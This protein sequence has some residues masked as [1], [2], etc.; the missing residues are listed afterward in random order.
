[1]QNL[2]SKT[3]LRQ[4]KVARSKVHYRHEYVITALNWTQPSQA[5]RVTPTSAAVA[6]PSG[7]KRGWRGADP[8]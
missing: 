4:R 3:P 7:V 5:S 2:T 1:M 8:A 6:G